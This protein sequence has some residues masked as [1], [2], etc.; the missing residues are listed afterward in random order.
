MRV[1]R[2]SPVRLVPSKLMTVL[3]TSVFFISGI[4]VLVLAA[5][6]KPI[7]RGYRSHDPTGR[8]EA[9]LETAATGDRSKIPQLIG[10]LDSD[11]S[12]VR[13]T[14]IGTL[15]RLTGQT[16]GYDYAAPER[17][18]RAATDR[19]VEWYED[20]GGTSRDGGMDGGG[21]AEVSTGEHE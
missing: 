5:C 2:E 4:G 7:P 13:F 20:E 11:D 21:A 12:A 16:L 10:E 18:R 9:M 1:E 3:R 17:E 8:I 19:W 15:E 14:A 6:T